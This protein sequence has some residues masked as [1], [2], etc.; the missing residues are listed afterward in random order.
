MECEAWVKLK[1]E[2]LFS[3]HLDAEHSSGACGAHVGPY[4]DFGLRTQKSSVV[5]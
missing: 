3:R 5:T 1:V 4:L 2:V